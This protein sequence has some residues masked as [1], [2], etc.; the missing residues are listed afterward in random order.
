[1][2][3]A[4]LAIDVG[5]WAWLGTMYLIILTWQDHRNNKMAVDD[6]KNWFML[7][8]SISII[9]HIHHAWY[10]VL[11]VLAV[12]FLF[13]TYGARIIKRIGDADITGLSWLILGYALMSWVP[14][15]VFFI[16]LAGIS[17]LYAIFKAALEKALKREQ[18]VPFFIVLLLSFIVTNVVLKLY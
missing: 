12:V 6:R 9:S 18:A 4:D 11:W 14:L 3:L 7:G 1:M 2:M 5:Y 17:S 10:Y 8:L 15:V 16:V 13:N